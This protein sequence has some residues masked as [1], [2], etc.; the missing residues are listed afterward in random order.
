MKFAYR[1]AAS[2]AETSRDGIL[3]LASKIGFLALL[4]RLYA[5]NEPKRETTREWMA[6]NIGKGFA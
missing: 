1:I 3:S 6:R 4:Y 5:L 2:D